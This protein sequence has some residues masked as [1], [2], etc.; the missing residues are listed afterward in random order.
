MDGEVYMTE[1]TAPGSLV[2]TRNLDSHKSFQGDKTAHIHKH[3]KVDRSEQ[4]L[5]QLNIT[6]GQAKQDTQ[7]LP[8]LVF[9]ICYES[10]I[11]S[12]LTHFS[13]GEGPQLVRGLS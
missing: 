12:K 10:I 9:A 8:V 11:I 6:T 4:G 1:E 2:M 3:F 7:N 5:L 13:S